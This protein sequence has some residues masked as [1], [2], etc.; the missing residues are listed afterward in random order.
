MAGPVRFLP[1][2]GPSDGCRAKSGETER[3]SACQPADQAGLLTH[4][5]VQVIPLPQGPQSVEAASLVI[6]LQELD[7]AL[8]NG[9]R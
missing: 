5:E 1:A 2:P 9:E 6:I 7:T 8:K 3:V 4:S